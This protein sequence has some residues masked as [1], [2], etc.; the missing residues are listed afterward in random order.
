MEIFH[1]ALDAR[2]RLQGSVL[3][4]GNFDGVHLGHQALL[5]AARASSCPIKSV[6]T[7]SP[8]P[9]T[10]TLRQHIFSL[11]NDQQKAR[12]FDAL[13]MD[14]AIFQMVDPE[15]LSLSAEEFA[16]KILAD[17]LKV[18]E[19]VVGED[20][21]FGAK[22]AGNVDYLKELAAE[23]LF[24]TTVVS[25]I[26]S[27]QQRASSSAIRQFLRQ[28][29]LHQAEVMLGRPYS[30]AGKVLA[31]QRKGKTLGFATANLAPTAG[32]AL[33][34]GVYASIT[35]IRGENGVTDFPSAT[36]VGVR[37]TLEG[38]ASLTIETHVLDHEIELYEQEIEVFFIER[39]RDEQKFADLNE[40]MLAVEKDLAAARRILLGYKVPLLS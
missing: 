14:I 16:V 13:G 4:I 26:M 15:F 28:G 35:R 19:I 24:K 39:L 36:N 34:N 6:L 31:G 30:F 22:A 18:D 3:A 8:H 10:F 1:Q 17:V 5:A 9:T 33:K 38:P 21:T 29:E 7:F 2:E 27:G 37:P 23:G 20:F 11:T 40:L 25:K 12:L 32:F